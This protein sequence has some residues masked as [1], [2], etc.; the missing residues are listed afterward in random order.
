MENK[1]LVTGATGN[2]GSHIV[3][4][5][6]NRRADFVAGTSTNPTDGATNSVSIDFADVASLEKAMHGISTLFMLMPAHPDTVQWGRNL[7]SAAKTS[8]VKYIVRSSSDVAYKAPSYNF[9]K[10]IQET[11]QD[12]ISSGLNYTIT[13][14]Q[15]F[16]QNFSTS[17]ADD[18][19]NGALY[20]PAGDGKVGWVDVR[21]IAA[22]NVEVLLNPEKFNHQTLTITGSESFSY[23]EVV[24]QMNEVLGKETQYIAVP[25]DTAIKGMEEK[26]FPP[27]FVGVMMNLSNAVAEG[28]ADEVT[29]TVKNVTG[30]K[31]ISFK[32]FVADNKEI[33]L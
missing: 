9:M 23:G 30:Q 32:Q 16:M 12:V 29:D 15:F 14:P 31:P 17:L 20:L 33:W 13:A 27:F 26:H 18:Y 1:I 25:D 2:I 11:D 19:K 8:G 5:L 3:R 21:D 4:L 10:L 6:K 28:H 24:N 7:I 22:V